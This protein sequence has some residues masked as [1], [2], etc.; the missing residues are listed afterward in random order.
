MSLLQ[1]YQFISKYARWNKEQGRRETWEEAVQRVVTYLSDIVE[2]HTDT[3]LDYFTQ[4]KL[5]YAILH[6]DIAPSMRLFAMAGEAAEANGLSIYNCSFLPVD[7]LFSFCEA[8]ALSMSGTGVGFS[9][10]EAHVNKL[11]PLV[12]DGDRE[13]VY[14]TVEDSTK[15]WVLA[16][17]SF[18]SGIWQDKEVIVD[19][20]LV[21]PQ[22]AILKTKGGRASGAAPLKRLF[23]LIE[24]VAGKARSEGRTQ[25]TPLEAH[26]IM[27]S[28][29]ACA[30][31]GGVRRSAMLSLFD[32]N[33]EEM[34]T[35][36]TGKWYLEHPYRAYA[37]NSAVLK[38]EDATNG[39][40]DKMMHTLFEGGTGE[41]GIFNRDN[42]N[43]Q[44]VKIGR[45]TNEHFG[46]N[47]C[48][49]IVLKPRQLCNLSSVICRRQDTMH[50][51]FKKAAMATL[52][53][54]IQSLVTNF[55]DYMPQEWVDNCE[56][57]R[58]IGVDLNGVMDAQELLLS[59]SN[60][61]A[62]QQEVWHVN[63]YW[64]DQFGINTSA[65]VTCIKPSGNSSVLYDTSSGIHTRHAPYYIRRVRESAHS[66]V[67]KMLIKSGM[68]WNAENGQSR[69]NPDTLVFSFPVAAPSEVVKYSAIGQLRIWLLFKQ[70][71]TTH[72]PSV[73][74]T[75]DFGEIEEI[76]QWVRQNYHDIGGISFI[77]NN[78]DYYP[79]MPYEEISGTEYQFLAERM[80]TEF[81]IAYLNSI[82]YE[83]RTESAQELA[84]FAGVCE[85]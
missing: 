7:S 75:Y 44:A 49:E 41:P 35:A 5:Y 40:L 9:V 21:R 65:S 56:E 61:E 53:G 73:T 10:E 68:P 31:S 25:I 32:A 69:S 70:Y 79:Q 64:A 19:F 85:I 11:P 58:L 84:C 15:G 48:A 67:A 71:Y 83:D 46:L 1:E 51:L 47:P 72:N 74:I 23:S 17:E 13:V 4:E 33:N 38:D 76:K 80:P 39:R 27:C 26:D 59:A 52:V 28:V 77:M 63:K 29:G 2:K 81:D 45:A 60:L 18:L 57:E 54:T 66:P 16:L 62:L 82:E 36:K 30:I 24:K 22:G 14:L 55:P 6:E 8:L 12:I 20:S 78:H 3:R 43:A 37:N 50:D 34:L 42:A